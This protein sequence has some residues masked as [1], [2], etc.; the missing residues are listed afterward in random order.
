MFSVFLGLVY[1]MLQVVKYWYINM[2]F[3]NIYQIYIINIYCPAFS[4]NRHVNKKTMEQFVDAVSAAHLPALQAQGYRHF[5]LRHGDGFQITCK[6]NARERIE[7]HD[8]RNQL[9]VIDTK[10]LQFGWQRQNP[11]FGN[12]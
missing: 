8:A 4:W 3:I 10:C 1:V 5:G 2:Y 11:D 9:L 6:S 7:I 12:E